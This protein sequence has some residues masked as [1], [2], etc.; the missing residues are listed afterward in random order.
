MASPQTAQPSFFEA[1]G[2]FGSPKGYWTNKSVGTRRKRT[3]K[4]T[5]L[6]PIRFAVELL[7]ILTPSASR[8][9]GSSCE[10]RSGKGNCVNLH[11]LE[12]SVEGIFVQ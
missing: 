8:V 5:P 4:W 2:I 7:Q 11:N 10:R 6:L 3:R 12:S 9:G 1:D